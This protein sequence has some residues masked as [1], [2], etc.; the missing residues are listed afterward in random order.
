VGEIHIKEHRC[1]PGE[2]EGKIIWGK[3]VRNMGKVMERYT[4]ACGQMGKC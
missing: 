4:T 2:I 1:K 3:F